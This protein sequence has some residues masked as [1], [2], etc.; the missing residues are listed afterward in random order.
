MKHG[1]EDLRNMENAIKGPCKFFIVLRK[2]REI[3]KEMKE[4]VIV[5]SENHL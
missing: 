1:S 5:L 4:T 3:M 2:E